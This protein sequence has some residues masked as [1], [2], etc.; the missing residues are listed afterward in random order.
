[1]EVDL[2]CTEGLSVVSVFVELLVL[3]VYVVMMNNQTVNIH[4]ALGSATPIIE[5]K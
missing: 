5:L 1:M 2:T 3:H 4:R